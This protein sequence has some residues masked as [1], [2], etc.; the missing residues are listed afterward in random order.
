MINSVGFIG[1]GNIGGPMAR[2]LLEGDFA[3]WV[4]DISEGALVA[5]EDTSARIASSFEEI[6]QNCDLIC[7]CVRN[8]MDIDSVLFSDR[9][10]VAAAK[11]G[12]IIA[13]HSTITVAELKDLEA[14]LTK[15]GLKLVDAPMT[16][17]AMGAEAKTLCYM[18]GASEAELGACRP[19][20]ETSAEKIIHAG[21]AGA[22]MTL[23]LCN[24]L[25]A[26]SAFIAVA[27]AAKLAEAAGL[28]LEDL[29]EIGASNG[30]ITPQMAAFIDNRN[31]MRDGLTEEQMDQ[32][33]GPFGRL[34]V[35]DLSAALAS[36]REL[37]IELPATESNI[38]LIENTFLGKD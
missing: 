38:D 36:A 16:G 26:N 19:A 9:G 20:F 1:L 24:N 34:G 23:K 25:M 17:G 21:P 10:I 30:V 32:F 7:L 35:K 28:P 12:T 6:G 31:K 27:E 15:E 5:F 22:G 13:V 8:A 14:R 4:F 37:G 3:T 11:K 33:F 18:V 29:L 2:N